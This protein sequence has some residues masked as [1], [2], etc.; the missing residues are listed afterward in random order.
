[1]K[2]RALHI[3]GQEA[4]IELTFQQFESLGTGKACRNFTYKDEV[5][6]AF[7]RLDEVL[8]QR[9]DLTAGDLWG[10]AGKLLQDRLS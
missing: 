6:R 1:M 8:R 7:G 10:Y 2:D 9:P 4:E 5:D 3:E